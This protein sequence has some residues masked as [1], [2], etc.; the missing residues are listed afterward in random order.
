MLL[1]VVAVRRV[2][3]LGVVLWGVIITIVG[4]DL[5]GGGGGSE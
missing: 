1:S 5:G 3:L 4:E 2:L